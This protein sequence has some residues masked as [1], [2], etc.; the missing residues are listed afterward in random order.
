MNVLAKEGGFQVEFKN[1]PLASLFNSL[2][3]GDVDFLAS[4][5]RKT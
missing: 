2:K 5:S 4:I 3:N 1:Q